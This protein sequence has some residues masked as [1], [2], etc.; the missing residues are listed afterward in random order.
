MTNKSI[1]NWS[2]GKDSALALYYALQDDRFQIE[3]LL[4]NVN[5]AFGRVSMH[6]VREVLLEQQAASIGI[7]LHKLRLP[8]QPT[9]K[10]YNTLMETTMQAF[11]R[12]DFTQAL[13]GDIFLE[14]LKKYREDHLVE[15]G[16]TAHFPL[17]QQ[18]TSVL[19]RDF[20]ALGFK[21]IVVCVKAE[22][23]D[24]SFVGRLIDDDF[25][26]DLPAGVDPCGENGEFH[27]FVYKGPIFRQPIAFNVG[28][29]VFRAYKAPASN[30]T[31]ERCSPGD[32]QPVADM[33]FW[34]CDLLPGSLSL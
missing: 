9:M 28:E 29:K 24:K 19:I 20:L 34:F 6:G 1:F 33:G 4:T 2:G 11:R 3:K 31:D 13:F 32:A 26:K 23:L 10:E 5:S 21:A 30:D 15:V 12:Q 14:D 22:L 18:D 17:W 27:T 16:F 7:P 25:L 8:E